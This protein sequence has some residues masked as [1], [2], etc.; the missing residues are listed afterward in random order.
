MVGAAKRRDNVR[1]KEFVAMVYRRYTREFKEEAVKLAAEVGRR[2]AARRL[3][4][5]EATVRVWMDQAQGTSGTTVPQGAQSDDPRVLRA[6]IKDLQARLRQSEI[7][8]EILKKAAAFF[9]REQT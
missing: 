9:A 5:P 8:K 2:E 3:G 4:V 1:R 6:Q 7:D